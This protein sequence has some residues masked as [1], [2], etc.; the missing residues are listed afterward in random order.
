[1]YST[2]AQPPVKDCDANPFYLIKNILMSALFVPA[3][4]GS[5]ARTRAAPIKP[6][7]RRRPPGESGQRALAA[8]WNAGVRL[9]G[10]H[11][12]RDG[13]RVPEPFPG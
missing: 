5:T 13:I 2:R 7:G 8:I 10:E 12:K 9:P 11:E 1:M 6:S 4:D 3:V